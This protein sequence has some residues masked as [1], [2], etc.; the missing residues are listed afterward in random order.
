MANIETIMSS[1]PSPILSFCAGALVPTLAYF[2]LL[3]G[4]AG[5]E[6]KESSKDFVV[7]DDDGF[8]EDSEDN[9]QAVPQGIENPKKWGFGDAPYKVRDFYPSINP[10]NGMHEFYCCFHNLSQNEVIICNFNFEFPNIHIFER[11]NM[12]LG[13]SMVMMYLDG[14]FCNGYK[15][16]FMCQSGI[17]NGKGQSCCSMWPCSSGLLQESFETLSWS[18][19]GMGIYWMCQNCC[20]VSNRRAN[21]SY[22]GN[23]IRSRNTLLLSGRCWKNT[24]CCW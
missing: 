4:K 12:D 14:C 15:D 2:L 9:E 17:E 21:G 23:G 13:L 6:T 20:Q 1:S 24:D 18:P 3:R 19:S 7:N 8:D 16:D 5:D 22:N 10:E 11:M